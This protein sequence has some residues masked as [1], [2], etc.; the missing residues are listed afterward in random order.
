MKYFHSVGWHLISDEVKREI[1][2]LEEKSKREETLEELTWGVIL[3]NL[4]PDLHLFA[5]ST[6]DKVARVSE[7]HVLR[8]HAAKFIWDPAGALLKNH[9]QFANLHQ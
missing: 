2:V 4:H 8:P 7:I 3:N 6:L 9:E 1:N 5:I